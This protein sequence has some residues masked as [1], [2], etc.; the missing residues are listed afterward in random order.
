MA[1]GGSTC[2][3]QNMD[4]QAGLE[5]LHPSLAVWRGYFVAFKKVVDNLL[6][7]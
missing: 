1:S 7:R 3:V 5:S 6:R 2:N 4:V